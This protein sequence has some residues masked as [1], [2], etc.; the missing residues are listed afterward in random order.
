VGPLAVLPPLALLAVDLIV[1][2]GV[3]LSPAELSAVPIWFERSTVS[4][5]VTVVT[6]GVLSL[7]IAVSGRRRADRRLRTVRDDS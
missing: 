5:L 6:L 3:R 7:A 4:V 2:V 1:R